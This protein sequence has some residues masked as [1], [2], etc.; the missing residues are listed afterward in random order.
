ME[1]NMEL[2]FREVSIDDIEEITE[3]YI[4]TYKK[5]PWK[6]N[7]KTE[8]ARKKIKDAIENNIGEKYC[9]NKDNKIIGIMFGHRNYLIDKKELY[10]DEYFIEYG[11]Q[12]Q[13]VGKYFLEYIEKEMK[14][15]NYSNII[16]L[17]EK[18]FPSELF[19][20]KNG[21]NISPNMVLMYKRII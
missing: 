14:Q 20:K 15:K 1:E 19:Y 17:T 11:N 4:E 7:W 9:V 6:E 21:F 10:V 16:L 8:I 12:R 18:A 5:E 3:L 13:G 2:K